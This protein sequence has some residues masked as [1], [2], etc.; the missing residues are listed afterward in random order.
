MLE[1]LTLGGD[2]AVDELADLLQRPTPVLTLPY[3][4]GVPLPG[5]AAGD[6]DRAR[7]GGDF[8]ESDFSFFSLFSLET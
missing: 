5:G 2:A 1:A 7:G 4:D 3:G 8:S 6:A